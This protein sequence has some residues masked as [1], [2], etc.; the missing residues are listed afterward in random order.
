M[1]YIIV[2]TLP[3]NPTGFDVSHNFNVL[4]VYKLWALQDSILG[5]DGCKWCVW[6]RF[7]FGIYA[8]RI[9]SCN[10]LIDVIYVKVFLHQVRFDLL[11]WDLLRDTILIM[12]LVLGY[13]VYNVLMEHEAL[14]PIE[15]RDLNGLSW[16]SMFVVYKNGND[17]FIVLFYNML[18]KV[19][20]HLYLC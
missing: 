8:N 5:Y 4:W 13:K 12:S 17:L 7:W 18:F 3:A 6:V 14:V 1:Q 16:H 10:L 20:T 9:W 19:F 2:L 11:C 15:L